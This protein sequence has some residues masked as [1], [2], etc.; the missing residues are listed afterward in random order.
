MD[1]GHSHTWYVP[2]YKTKD[3]K[4]W[5]LWPLTFSKVKGIFLWGG[6]SSVLV[7]RPMF[8]DKDTPLNMVCFLLFLYLLIIAI[9]F[10]CFGC[11][12]TSYK[13]YKSCK[14]ASSAV[15]WTAPQYLNKSI[16][17]IFQ[18]VKT[19]TRYKSHI[20]QHWVLFCSNITFILLM[21]T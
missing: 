7:S 3:N 9:A 6:Q 21:N 20:F 11:Q 5:Y 13:S 2:T 17:R 18:A 14:A 12:K 4:T 10:L 16:R 8:R 15:R 19:K 1:L